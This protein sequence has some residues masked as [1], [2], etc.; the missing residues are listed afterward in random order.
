M[1][2][3]VSLILSLVMGILLC[4]PAGASGEVL[5][6]WDWDTTLNIRKED[7]NYV[8]ADQTIPW[9]TKIPE[10]AMMIVSN[11][12][13]LKIKKNF[14]VNGVLI[15]HSG[16]K[17]LVQS[18]G[19]LI[20]GKNGVVVSEG[21]VS[22]SKG[23]KLRCYGDLQTSGKVAVKGVLK[24][25]ST[26]KFTY[27]IAPRAY[28]GGKLMGR[29]SKITD[30]PEYYIEDLRSLEGKPLHV[31]FEE[32]RE[33]MNITCDR[34][35]IRSAA[36][37]LYKL[38]R[39]IRSKE[40]PST[41][42]ELGKLMAQRY[43]TASTTGTPLPYEFGI[44]HDS[45]IVFTETSAKTGVTSGSVYKAVLGAQTDRWYNELLHPDSDYPVPD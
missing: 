13:A 1:K 3:I 24:T 23:G 14:T 17:V 34:Q 44:Y 7:A 42:S 6:W 41:D 9:S 35:I 39:T 29:R 20:I 45:I 33:E 22:V 10:G 12:A 19:S 16:S 5:Q 26:G 4:V 21:T 18:G 28:S 11:G 38:D 43:I 15:V 37:V 36:V 40:Y 30:M 25:Y 27:D 31:R 8:V 2:K 32:T